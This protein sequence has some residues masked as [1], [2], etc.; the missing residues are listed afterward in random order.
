V[1]RIG[2]QGMHGHGA[3]TSQRLQ[4][5]GERHGIPRVLGIRSTPC[6]RL[7]ANSCLLLVV[8]AISEAECV[9]LRRAARRDSALLPL[10]HL[11]VSKSNVFA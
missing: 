7:H 10:R 11:T 9:G 2:S 3:H 5:A 4:L 6:R 8:V 1:A